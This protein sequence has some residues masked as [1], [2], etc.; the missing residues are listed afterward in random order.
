M[1]KLKIIKVEISLKRIFRT[2][3]LEILL[4]NIL[5]GN[6]DLIPSRELIQSNVRACVYPRAAYRDYFQ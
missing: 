5:R 4:S 1:G 3:L 6:I 2:N